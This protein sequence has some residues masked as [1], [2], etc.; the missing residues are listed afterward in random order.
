MPQHTTNTSTPPTNT[1]TP[2]PPVE[3]D[4][5]KQ[6]M[7]DFIQKDWRLLPSSTLSPLFTTGTIK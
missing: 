3:T 7:V 5:A 2:I 4:M 6:Y 1:C